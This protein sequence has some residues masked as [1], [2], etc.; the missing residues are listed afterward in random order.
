ML[1]KGQRVY[2]RTGIYEENVQREHEMIQDNNTGECMHDSERE[3]RRYKC[4]YECNGLGW[5]QTAKR[6]TVVHL[7]NIRG[8]VAL[9]R[10]QEEQE[11]YG[12]QD[13]QDN[14]HRTGMNNERG[15]SSDEA[16]APF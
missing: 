15:A 2:E 8:G 13:M 6:P 10:Q 12:Q 7:R 16:G 11:K 9:G 5:V 1:T 14:R 4:V 3:M